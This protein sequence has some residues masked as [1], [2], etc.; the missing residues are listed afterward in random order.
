MKISILF[1]K[2]DES[3]SRHTPGQ[4]IITKVSGSSVL[5][6]FICVT[7]P[8]QEQQNQVVFVLQFFLSESK[9]L[10]TN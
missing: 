1:Y 9:A 10:I 5:W 6:T 4:R 8:K 2:L 3:F 7:L